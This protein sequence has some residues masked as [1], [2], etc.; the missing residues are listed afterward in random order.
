MSIGEQVADCGGRRFFLTAMSAAINTILFALA[1]LSESG[2]VTLQIAIVAA[3]ITGNA[4]QK[5]TE[6]RYGSVDSKA[7]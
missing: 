7:P 4:A 1:I 5:Y 2:Y 6:A 3:Y